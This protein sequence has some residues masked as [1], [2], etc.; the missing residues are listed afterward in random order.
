MVGNV[1]AVA[2][3]GGSVG[4]F[5]IMAILSDGDDT[6]LLALI[7]IASCAPLPLPV[8]PPLPVV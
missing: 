7:L 8:L 4:E 5:N 1:V 6:L 3:D 2:A